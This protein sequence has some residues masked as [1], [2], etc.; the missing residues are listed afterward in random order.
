MLRVKR[1][2]RRPNGVTVPS[3]SDTL[4]HRALRIADAAAVAELYMAMERAEPVDE[5]FDE[6]D[7]IEELSGPRADLGRGSL[8]IFEDDRLVAVGWLLIKSAA[9]EDESAEWEVSLAGGVHPDYTGRGLGR[10]IVQEL[11]E[12]A[13]Q[14]RDADAAG[15]PGVL[16]AGVDELRPRTT[17]LIAAAGYETWRYF[18]R[19]RCDLLAVRPAVV[20][21]VGVDVRP[22][23]AADDDAVRRVSNEAW[24]DHW[25]SQPMDQ[26][27]WRAQFAESGSFRPKHS[28]VAVLDGRIVGFVLVSEFDADTEQRGYRTG[29]IGRVGTLR[30]ARGRSIASTLLADS[31]D[32]LAAAGYCSAELDV[33]AESPTGAGPLYERA[34]FVTIGQMRIFGRRF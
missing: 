6:Q 21:P 7:F 18:L 32:S 1:S 30:R 27:T 26:A 16:K 8:G 14:I 5:A 12:R 10:R 24:A 28:R 2:I 15:S 17:A 3:M 23:Q 4:T 20:V 34:G 13:V 9:I 29:Y 33:D 19:M 31:L 11:E 22:Y 25:G